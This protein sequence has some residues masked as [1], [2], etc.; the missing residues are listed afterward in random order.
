MVQVK[1]FEFA[2]KVSGEA[3]SIGIRRLHL[4]LSRLIV[5][6]KGYP[7]APRTLGEHVRKRRFDLGLL[8]AQVAERIG[9]T[10]STV[11]NWEHGRSPDPKHHFTIIQF[12][13]YTPMFMNPAPRHAPPDLDCDV[14][15][16]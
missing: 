10:A 8:Q 5:P 16:E 14:E 1:I 2:S 9:V 13:G 15:H 12:L 4:T 3:I 7:V 11:W 6:P